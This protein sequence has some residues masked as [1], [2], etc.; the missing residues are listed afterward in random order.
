VREGF[1]AT[2]G[3][4]YRSTRACPAAQKS[5]PTRSGIPINL[6]LART[7]LVALKSP[8]STR[9]QRQCPQGPQSDTSEEHDDEKQDDALRV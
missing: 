7:L 2:L 4:I 6:P 8:G 5:P 3:V 1:Y 9:R